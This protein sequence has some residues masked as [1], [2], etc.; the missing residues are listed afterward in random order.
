MGW[1]DAFHRH[2][3]LVLHPTHP[4]VASPEANV[5]VTDSQAGSR[6]RGASSLTL[7]RDSEPY[8][9]LLAAMHGGL[10]VLSLEVYV[11]GI[12]GRGSRGLEASPS[13]FLR[14]T[15]ISHTCHL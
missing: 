8:W 2:P 7:S 15:G 3:G 6:L 14:L 9:F 12:P 1:E 4:V 11:Q 5:Q 10:P 13:V